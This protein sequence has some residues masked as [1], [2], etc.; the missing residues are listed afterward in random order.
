MEF[1]YLPKSSHET[2]NLRSE[3]HLRDAI[4]NLQ[5][6]GNI[7]VTGRID[8]KTRMYVLKFPPQALNNMINCDLNQERVKNDLLI[9]FR[10]LLK[11]PRCGVPD[12]GSSRDFTTRNRRY[13]RYVI[14]EQRWKH[15]NLTW[16]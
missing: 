16:R 6:F 1:G 7:P 4:K 2:G 11:S 15:F 10:R 9:V 12:A 5:R 3:E 13:K 14:H 8:A